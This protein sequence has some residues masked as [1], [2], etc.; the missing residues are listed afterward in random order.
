M[1]AQISAPPQHVRLPPGVQQPH[2]SASETGGIGSFVPLNELTGGAYGG[3]DSHNDD[4]TRFDASAPSQLNEA[5]TPISSDMNQGGRPEERHP[6][7]ASSD[8]ANA[9]ERMI[10]DRNSERNASQQRRQ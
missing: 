9:Y 10:A 8:V 6:G 4:L 1:L 2:G 3:L 7:N 5:Y